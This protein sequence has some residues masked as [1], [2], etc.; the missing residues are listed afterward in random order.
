VVVVSCAR[1]VPLNTTTVRST[2]YHDTTAALLTALSRSEPANSGQRVD[3]MGK[4]GKMSTMG[5]V[6]K[7]FIVPSG[8]A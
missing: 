3:I 4:R 6:G 8:V 7:G 1:S 5:E 2:Y